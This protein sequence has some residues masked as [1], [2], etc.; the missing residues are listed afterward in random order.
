VRRLTDTERQQRRDSLADHAAVLLARASWSALTVD[1]VAAAAGVAK[2]S[3]FLAFASKEDLGL[4]VVGR[5]FDAWFERLVAIDPGRP[6]PEVAN[7]LLVSLRHDPLLLPLMALVG[8]VLE[9]GCSAAA[10]VGFKERLARNLAVLIRYWAP[11][12]P[13]VAADRWLPWF[14]GVH[15]LIV[16]AWTVGETSDRVRSALADRPDLRPLLTRFDD[17]LV[18]LLEA[19]LR[20]MLIP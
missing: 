11:R 18:P 2:G 3:V 6:V 9:A 15:A 7:A 1:A 4:H 12:R 14:L 13:D 19:E 10:I 5:R 16:G 17:V 8:P 20:A